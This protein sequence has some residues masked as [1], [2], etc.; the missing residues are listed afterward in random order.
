MSH[1]KHEIAS[2]AA[3]LIVE[4]GLNYYEAKSKAQESVFNQYGVKTNKKSLPNKLE[5]EIAIRKH[6]MLF[7]KHEYKL[8]LTELREKAKNLMALLGN[9][10]PLLIGSIST[11]TVTKYSDIR[12]CCFADTSKEI[13][14]EL[15]NRQVIT[16]SCMLKHPIGRSKVEGLTFI[17]EQEPTIIYTLM[18]YESKS[19][20]RG[21]NYKALY[22]LID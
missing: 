13:A 1:I 11:E 9:F 21:L 5:L 22:K 20:L 3:R 8:R 12:I 7:F 6:L 17:W 4:E 2:I 10:M 16:D 18:N 15:L 19:K 14:I